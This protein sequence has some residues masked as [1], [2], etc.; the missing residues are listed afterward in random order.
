MAGREKIKCYQYDSNGKYLGKYNSVSELRRKYFNKHKGKTPLFI[1]K[2][3][4]VL[5]DNTVATLER[6]G[7]DEV[8]RIFKI[9]HNPLLKKYNTKYNATPIEIYDILGNKIAEFKNKSCAEE[10]LKFSKSQI[11][12]YLQKAGNNFPNNDLGISIKYKK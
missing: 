2:N 8:K 12:G 1:S 6:L 4:H 11:Y 3:Y 10:L 7:R 5:P 9:H